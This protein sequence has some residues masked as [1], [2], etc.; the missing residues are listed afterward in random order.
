MYAGDY[1]ATGLSN[2]QYY[3][4]VVFAGCIFYVS[5]V[6]PCGRFYYDGE[7]GFFGNT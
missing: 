6:L 3:S 2:M 1:L 4:F 7:H 5:S